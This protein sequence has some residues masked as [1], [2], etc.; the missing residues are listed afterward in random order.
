[1]FLL[2]PLV[3]FWFY[4]FVV[5]KGLHKQIV[6]AIVDE[7]LLGKQLSACLITLLHLLKKHYVREIE[8]KVLNKIIHCVNSESSRPSEV[9]CALSVLCQILY[10]RGQDLQNSKH[11]VSICTSLLSDRKHCFLDSFFD[12]CERPDT[13]H[14][15]WRQHDPPTQHFNVNQRHDKV[16]ERWQ[17]SWHDQ[18]AGKEQKSGVHFQQCHKQED[19]SFTWN[20][21]WAV[22]FTNLSDEVSS[23]K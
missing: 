15:E 12:I 14:V 17:T 7:Q 21:T 13:V 5:R 4:W 10:L 20:G 19:Y 9:Q 1:M 18:G 3:Y 8:E 2:L 22:C 6:T 11:T 16:P 23:I